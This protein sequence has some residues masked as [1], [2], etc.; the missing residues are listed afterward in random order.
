MISAI[1]WVRRGAASRLPRTEGALDEG[2][3]E[4]VSA[5]GGSATAA[6]SSSEASGKRRMDK[7]DDS[8][9]DAEED[10][11]R[12]QKLAAGNLMYYGSNTQDPNLQVRE[13]DDNDSE[14]EDFEIG[15]TDLVLLGARSDDQLSNLEA[16]VYEEP[17]DNLYPH[18]DIPLP[19]FPLCV[20]W[21]DFRPGG[22]PGRGNFAAIGTFEPYIEVWDLDIMDALEPYAVLGG[23]A[24]ALAA[25][26]QFTAHAAEALVA[27]SRQ[28]HGSAAAAERAAGKQKAP[29]RKKKLGGGSGPQGHT[30]AVMCLAW[31]PLQP[32]ALA[33][34]SADCTV[35][36][37]DLEGD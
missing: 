7:D 28:K 2:V 18:H 8:D 21:F 14:L 27:S 12:L 22:A 33:S 30:D 6:A 25:E 26:E 35:R 32:N 34:G 31:N 10:E 16:Y 5:E 36:L 19:V 17:A 37:W 11:H 23:E 20:A 24:A 9:S 13:D 3:L 4:D 29:K 15:P 1:A